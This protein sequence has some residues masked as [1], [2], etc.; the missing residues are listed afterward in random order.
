MSIRMS[1]TEMD[2]GYMDPAN[3]FPWISRSCGIEWL[4]RHSTVLVGIFRSRLWHWG[5]PSQV[6]VSE[7]LAE[8][9]AEVL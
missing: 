1:S 3:L 4:L 7:M 5:N 8:E 2:L 9:A 6:I